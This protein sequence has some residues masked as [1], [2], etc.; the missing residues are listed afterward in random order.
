MDFTK[1][2]SQISIKHRL[3]VKIISKTVGLNIN[4][5]HDLELIVQGHEKR[6]ISDILKLNPTFSAV[7]LKMAGSFVFRFKSKLLQTLG[8]IF[9]ILCHDLEQRSYCLGQGHG[10]Q[11]GKFLFRP[12]VSWVSIILVRCTCWSKFKKKLIMIAFV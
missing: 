8:D 7:D 10:V 12:M 1:W 5:F 6:L 3:Y 4:N 11:G 9:F 2:L